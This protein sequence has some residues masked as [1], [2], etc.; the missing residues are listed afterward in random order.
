M[1]ITIVNECYQYFSSEISELF[2]IHLR[3]EKNA[4]SAEQ[5]DNIELT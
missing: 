5:F 1:D 2:L 3:Q 4:L